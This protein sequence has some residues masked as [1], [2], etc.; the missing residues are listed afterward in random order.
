M[1]FIYRMILWVLSLA[2]V[3][4]FLVCTL[5]STVLGNKSS[6]A[7]YADLTRGQW[8]LFIEEPTAL[9][10]W[11]SGWRG[12]FTSWFS[13]WRAA[14]A[15]KKEAKRKAK[16]KAA[17]AAKL[18]ADK[19]KEE[20]AAAK[21]AKAAAK[22]AKGSLWKRFLV[23]SLNLV[24]PLLIEIGKEVIA[25]YEVGGV[26]MQGG[27]FIPEQPGQVPE[28]E[29]SDIADGD[30]GGDCDEEFLIE[31]KP[32]DPL[33]D[34]DEVLGRL[35]LHDE[36]PF[37]LPTET[38]EMRTTLEQAAQISEFRLAGMSL[39]WQE[40]LK[41]WASVCIGRDKSN[42]TALAVQKALTN[43][44]EEWSGDESAHQEYIRGYLVATGAR[45]DFP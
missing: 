33:G 38:D 32:V 29:S 19:A 3:A 13:D 20:K 24:K 21:E 5:V 16:A 18:K 10:H 31:T 42:M 1:N 2:A 9:L 7:R 45:P 6:T 41:L 26:R 27:V 23:H 8:S 40:Q 37:D 22:E 11:L 39:T 44:V 36:G 4:L 30:E 28:A 43:T 35:L 34:T 15:E 12:G 17:E 25:D 14:R